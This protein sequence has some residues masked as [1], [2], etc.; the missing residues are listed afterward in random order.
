MQAGH[1]N[2]IYIDIPPRPPSKA[3]IPPARRKIAHHFVLVHFDRPDEDSPAKMGKVRVAGPSQV[4]LRPFTVNVSHSFQT[5]NATSLGQGGAVKY[6]LTHLT[7]QNLKFFKEITA[8]TMAVNLFMNGLWEFLDFAS[9]YEVSAMP[10]LHL[11]LLCPE[12]CS[13]TISLP[14][15]RM[16][17][18]THWH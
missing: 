14:C 5:D 3:R 10:A 8:D 9:I 2:C 13:F 7:V 12:F 17:L 11:Y 15:N 4:A 18:L 16:Q 6:D 1:P